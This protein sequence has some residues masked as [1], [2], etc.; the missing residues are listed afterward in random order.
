MSTAADPDQQVGALRTLREMPSAGRLLLVGVFVNQLGAF[1][2]AFLVLYLAHRGFGQSEAL[3]GM[4]A[5]GA[6]AVVGLVF[7]GSMSDRLGP[8][9]TIMVSMTASAILPVTVTLVSEYAVIVAV[10]AV[11]GAMAQL[12]RPAAAAILAEL[13]PGPRQTM[14]FALNRLAIN[15][16]ASAGPLLAG[17]L[18]THDRW[19]L[20][21]WLDG[22]SAALYVLIAAFFLPRT[23]PGAGKGQA[24]D[25]GRYWD[26]LADP[27][28]VAFLVAVLGNAVVYI[29]IFTVLPLT[30]TD[31]GFADHDY[32]TVL[33]FGAAVIICCELVVTRF[34][35]RWPSRVAAATGLVLLGVGLA[36]YGLPVPAFALFFVGTAISTV[37]Q[38][39]GGPAIFAY[40]GKV[41]PAGLKGR[42]LGAFFG[43]F[44]L[45]QAVGP[46]VAAPIYQLL[47]SGIWFLSG[48][49]GVLSAGLAYLGME[50]APEQR[51]ETVEARKATQ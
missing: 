22:I 19:D 24:A 1:V 45:G 2:Q 44:G 7:G 35:Q 34:T 49:L 32:G 41:A 15:L 48:L 9:R 18:I 14:A 3:F 31:R 51:V 12:Y 42:Y 10:V 13:V 36:C 39:I 50:Q 27:R 25:R 23:T 37:G 47:G 8:R 20:L 33:A 6:G 11:A 30:M 46:V 17:V 5:Y 16:G 28:Y 38:I 29:Q 26:V 40:P 4:G 43:M 21:F